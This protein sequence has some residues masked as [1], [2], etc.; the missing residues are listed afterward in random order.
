MKLSDET[1]LSALV[2]CGS[3]S[4]AAKNLGCST[5]PI[6]SRLKDPD[7]KSEVDRLR[8]ENM[9]AACGALQCA[10][11]DAIQTA[12]GILN[13]TENSPQ[14]RLNAANMVLS[15]ALRYTEQHDIL[16]RLEALEDAQKEVS[17]F[18]Y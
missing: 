18:G 12:R 4:A 5:Q 2:A 17:I 7:F 11:L 9:A 15:N 1:I 3:V 6:Y 13:D 16:Q 14:I 8:R 10:L